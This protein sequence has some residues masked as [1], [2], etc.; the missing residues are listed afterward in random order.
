MVLPQS[1]ETSQV[2]V[3]V[4]GQVPEV[5]SPLYTTLGLAVQLSASSVISA[6]L[7]DGT[8]VMQSNVA[9]AG[10]V[11]VGFMLSSTVIVCVTKIKFPQS[12]VT[13]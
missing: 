9:F 6:A 4:K 11:A 3:M 12:S 2:R 1:S 8:L 13:R 7:A 10:A 5:V